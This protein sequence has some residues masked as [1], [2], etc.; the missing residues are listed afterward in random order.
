MSTERMAL[1]DW[2]ASS[3]L[4]MALL[5]MSLF[6][7]TSTASRTLGVLP[8]FERPV[9]RRDILQLLMTTEEGAI[10]YRPRGLRFPSGDKVQHI[11]AIVATNSP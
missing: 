8:L 10:E 4:A 5:F 11:T 2:I 9:D 3:L 1:F 7:D 6:F